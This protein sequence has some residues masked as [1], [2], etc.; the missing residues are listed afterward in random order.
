MAFKTLLKEKEKLISFT[1]LTGLSLKCEGGVIYY[2][3]MVPEEERH[4]SAMKRNREAL[5]AE[6]QLWEGYLKVRL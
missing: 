2:N 6:L 3:Y 5:T 4:D 1:Q